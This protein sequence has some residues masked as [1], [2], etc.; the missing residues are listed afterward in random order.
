[1]II[2]KALANLWIVQK[3]LQSFK[4]ISIK[5]K[6][7]IYTNYLHTFIYSKDRFCTNDTTYTPD[8]DKVKKDDMHKRY[9]V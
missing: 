1:M 8:I 6:E 3:T 2:S 4:E 5:S 9:N 7:E